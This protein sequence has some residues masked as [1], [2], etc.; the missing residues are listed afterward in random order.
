MLPLEPPGPELL[1]ALLGLLL[2]SIIRHRHFLIL[3]ACLVLC[4]QAHGVRHVES[5]ALDDA[6]EI[7]L[8]FSYESIEVSAIH[9]VDLGVIELGELLVDLWHGP[10]LL[11][12]LGDD[13]ER[14]LKT[15]QEVVE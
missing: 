11:D 10:C 4:L 3:D 14:V 7:D 6:L 13:I 12:P 2:Q 9:V 8:R 15:P 1:V 5:E